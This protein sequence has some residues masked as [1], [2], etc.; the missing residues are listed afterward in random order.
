MI[1]DPAAVLCADIVAATLVSGTGKPRPSRNRIAAGIFLF[2]VRRMGSSSLY[3]VD[4]SVDTNTEARLDDAVLGELQRAD[5]ARYL[6][7]RRGR[8]K[9]ERGT[10]ARVVWHQ[11][12]ELESAGVDS[13]TV[14]FLGFAE[15][16]P[17]FAIIPN[18]VPLT[19]DDRFQA[20]SEDEDYIGLRRAAMTMLP[21]EAR[22]AG[23]AVH[24][25]NWINRNRYCGSC[26]APMRIAEGGHKLL[27]SAAACGREE[28][29][30]TDP[31]VICLVI[32]GDRC[33]LA[34]QARFPPK[35]YSA[36]AG[37]VE[38]GE[39][40]E[41][42]VRREVREEAGVDVGE[43]R[44]VGS[45]PWPFPTSLMVGYIAHA[46]GD[47]FKLD[48]RELEDGRW[49]DRAEI[50]RLLALGSDASSAVLLPP[51]GVMARRL[52]DEWISPSA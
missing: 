32:Y 4:D 31:V 27:C 6:L 44:Y 23:H 38:P 1:S 24:L 12:P 2:Y 29:P 22:M 34:R 13:S 28:F 43:V 18:E 11:L 33:L 8:V 26:A 16:K 47:A 37:F 30:R 50:V 46:R 10:P 42:A 14:A 20:M 7:I 52:I 48:Q 17:R 21:A 35:F 9:A 36:L 3:F 25:A 15:G 45:Q 51:K 5:D 19:A 40:L 41:A 49:F 39:T